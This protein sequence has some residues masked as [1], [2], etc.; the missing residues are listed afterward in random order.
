MSEQHEAAAPQNKGPVRRAYDRLTKV[1]EIVVSV[2]MVL[3]VGLVFANVLSRYLL[4]FSIAWS[5]EIARYIFIWLVLLGAILAFQ[6]AEHLGIDLLPKALP[7][8]I[9][10]SLKV[11]TDLLALYAIYILLAGGWSYSLSSLEAGWLSPAAG[12]PLGI[13]Q[14]VLPVSALLLFLQ[15]I[16]NLV[17]DARAAI[18]AFRAP[19]GVD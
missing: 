12:I 5:S 2:L 15:G 1:I 8:R 10:R 19:K 4:N 11:F 7:P 6:N 9:G 16:G 3:M 14:M 13:V 17:L 18:D